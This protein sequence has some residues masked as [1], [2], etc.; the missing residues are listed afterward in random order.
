MQNR[1]GGG[2]EEHTEH[3]KREVEPLDP[4]GSATF[5]SQ[6]THLWQKNLSWVGKGWG[7]VELLNALLRG[8]VELESTER[9]TQG[10]QRGQSSV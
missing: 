1:A 9:S 6:T 8:E 3:G 4:P 2:W 5:F 10:G 7:K